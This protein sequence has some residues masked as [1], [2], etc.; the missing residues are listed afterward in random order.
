MCHKTKPKSSIPNT[1]KNGFQTDLVDL[2]SVIE[3]QNGL[4]VFSEDG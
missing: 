1:N 3:A 4:T 2:C